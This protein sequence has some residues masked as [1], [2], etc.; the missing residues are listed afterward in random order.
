MRDD[1]PTYLV[2]TA[3]SHFQLLSSA[4]PYSILVML[5]SQPPTECWPL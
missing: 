3:R 5:N 1:D 4:S 2:D